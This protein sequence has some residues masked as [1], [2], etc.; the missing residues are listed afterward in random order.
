MKQTIILFLII[1]QFIS[2]NKRTKEQ[3]IEEN[4]FVVLYSVSYVADVCDK[5]NIHL[6][7]LL[8]E[9]K[10]GLEIDKE[11]IKEIEKLSKEINK[12]VKVSLNKLNDKYK[13]NENEEIFKASI[14]YL[15]KINELEDKIPS[16]IKE[17]SENIPLTDFKLNDSVREHAIEVK[18]NYQTYNL[19]MNNYYKSNEM[20]DLKLDSIE[21]AVEVKTKQIKY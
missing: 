18:K 11:N 9:I 12:R 15:N 3:K 20:S 4:C 14:K 19:A 21:N 1:I 7:Q 8:N 17:L 5:R 16:F 13:E 10:N 2:C 6:T